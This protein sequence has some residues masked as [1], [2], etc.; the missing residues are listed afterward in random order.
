[1]NACLPHIHEIVIPF[2]PFALTWYFLVLPL[3][4]DFCI[5]D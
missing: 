1:M 2:S 3:Y 5:E 4:E